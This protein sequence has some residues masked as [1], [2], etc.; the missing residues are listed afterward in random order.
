MGAV[1]FSIHCLLWVHATCILVSNYSFFLLP[2]EEEEDG[3]RRRPKPRDSSIEEREKILAELDPEV[4]D[5]L[6][7]YFGWE[8]G[9]YELD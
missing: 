4:L 6:F 5:Y 1:K 7:D 9:L 3:V 8:K 2:R